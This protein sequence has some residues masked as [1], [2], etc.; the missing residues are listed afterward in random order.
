VVAHAFA[1]R[2]DETDQALFFCPADELLPECHR[3]VERGYLAR[4]WHDQ[5]LVYR[6]T[7]EAMTA[8]AGASAN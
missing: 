5:D 7:D 6:L 2:R 4:R 8:Q 1:L 3:L